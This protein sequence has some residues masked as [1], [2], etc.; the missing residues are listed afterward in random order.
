MG[1]G[2]E[3]GAKTSVLYPVGGTA[4]IQVDLVIA[5][6]F[7][8]FAAGCEILRITATELQGD[9]VFGLMILQV[10]LAVTVQQCTGGDHFRIEQG[11]PADQAQEIATMSVGPVQHRGYGEGSLDHGAIM[12][13]ETG[14][15]YPD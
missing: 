4:D 2:H 14:I 1:F 10:S 12:S 8:H 6:V 11:V 5:V 3:T 15:L 13:L 9:R 7:H